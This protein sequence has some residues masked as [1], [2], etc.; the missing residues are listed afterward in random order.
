MRPWGVH[1][2]LRWADLQASSGFRPDGHGPEDLVE[3]VIPMRT[4]AT[5]S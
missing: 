1:G 2:R 5:G 3:I 4:P